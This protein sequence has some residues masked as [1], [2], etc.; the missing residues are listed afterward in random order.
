MATGYLDIT[1]TTNLPC[2]NKCAYSMMYTTQQITAQ[3]NGT[4]IN[5]PYV[6]GSNT[7]IYNSQSY[8]LQNMMIIQPSIHK[9]N[10]ALTAGE[11]IIQHNSLEQ[12]SN[13]NVCIP[14]NTI[15]ADTS[16]SSKGASIV[17]DI[18]MAV[19]KEANSKGNST[20]NIREFSVKDIIP[21]TTY[22]TYEAPNGIHNIV[23][24][25]KNSINI[26]GSNLT[27]LKGCIGSN[28][29][30]PSSFYYANSDQL[31][32]SKNPPKNGNVGDD[33]YID[34]K[35]VG[36]GEDEDILVNSKSS[37]KDISWLS[38][39]Y[40]PSSKELVLTIITVIVIVILL[41][42]FTYIL[43]LVYNKQIVNWI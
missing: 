1:S 12:G 43:K 19:S 15:N 9:F 22:Y 40:T 30:D 33:I 14:I 5:I 11:I 13:L 2:E 35:L 27:T 29:L 34:C 10:G 38:A 32:I 28:N 37:G 16:N 3:N 20:S 4:Y 18:I 8:N 17:S 36:E 21:L 42:A 39:Y 7:V 24:D 31:F 25:L 41:M 6:P 26:S 23:F